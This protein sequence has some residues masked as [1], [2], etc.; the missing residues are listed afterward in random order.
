MYLPLP[1]PQEMAAWDK[2]SMD[3]FDLRPELL[4]E[5]A[6]REAFSQ[7]KSRFADLSGRTA[8]IF[9]GSGNN[10][11]DAFA[12]ARHLWN[13]GVKVMTLH[14]K[15]LKEYEGATG[16][17]LSV[18]RKLEIPYSY[19]SEYNLD[20]IKDVDIIVDGLLGTGFTGELR[21]DYVHWIKAI[22]K[23]GARA[24]VISLDIPSGIDGITGEPSPVAVKADDTV[25]FE[26]AKLGLMQPEAREYV[27]CLSIKKIGIPQCIKNDN[28]PKHYVLDID[29]LNRLETP[30][31]T[32]HKGEGG[33]V[34]VL[35][36]SQSLSGA[37]VLAC[38][39]ALRAGAGLVTL[40]CPADLA[41]QIRCGWPEIMTLPLGQ[42]F[43][44][45]RDMFGQ[46]KDELTRFDSVVVGPGMGR[47]DDTRE[48]FCDYLE[49][50]HPRTLFDADALYF[51][52]G[53]NSLMSRL[54]QSSEVVL[55]PHPGEMARFFSVSPAQVNQDRI[56]YVRKF[57]AKFRVNLVL[58]GASTLI[59]G[60]DQHFYISPFATSNLAVGGSG[61][62]LAGIIG[63]LMTQ[64]LST[65][66]AASLGVYWH[67]LSGKEL[68]KAYPFRGNMAREI[69]DTLPAVLS[70]Y[71]GKKCE[72]KVFFFC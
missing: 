41:G 54:S 22:N 29:I 70:R 28:P 26:E 55:T 37:A 52:A 38:L 49:N 57:S 16:Y 68:E 39:G 5:N 47:D 66:D 11:G 15:R 27:G 12:L 71:K 24:Y 33:H 60:V 56:S 65:L 53:D 6:S 31:R 14:S 61:D 35:G 42:G 51:L 34:L 18:L 46:L 20:F 63:S 1:T 36:G 67:G 69:A 19:L 25:A 45:R 2:R 3:E 48:F 17:H 72:D 40:A 59:A 43:Y 44:W 10:G 21:E 7:I 13:S 8:L 62:V 32:M 23:I 58:K 9:A 30:R 50:V 64:S 4:M